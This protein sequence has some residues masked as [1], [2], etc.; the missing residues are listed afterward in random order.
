MAHGALPV[1][2]ILCHAASLSTNMFAFFV[3]ATSGG[4]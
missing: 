2:P 1:V 3:G 4:L